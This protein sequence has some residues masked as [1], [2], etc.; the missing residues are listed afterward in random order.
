MAAAA[1]AALL[2][3]G[4]LA[5]SV[6]LKNFS[7]PAI[8][9]PTVVAPEAGCVLRAVKEPCCAGPGGGGGGGRA[10]PRA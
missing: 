5:A 4:S 8:V 7:I 6:G 2:P 9:D 10:K 3:A 1:A